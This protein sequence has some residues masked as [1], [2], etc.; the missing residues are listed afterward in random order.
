MARILRGKGNACLLAAMWLTGAAS[1]ALGQQSATGLCK[2]A[3]PAKLPEFEVATIKP[4]NPQGGIAGFWVYPGGRV[5]AGHM[6]LRMLLMFACNVQMFQVVG[7]PGWADKDF[8]NLQAKPSESSLSAKSN[9]PNPNF[10]PN[11]E[12]RQMLEALLI[13]RFQLK[14]H[15]ESR[16]G[17]VYVLERGSN[18]LKLDPVKDPNAPPWVGGAGKQGIFRLNGMSGQNISMPQLAASLSWF[19]QRP[20]IDRTGIEGSFDFEYKTGEDP[21][22]KAESFEEL[23]PTILTS[24]RGIGLKLTPAKGPVEAIVIDHAEEPSPN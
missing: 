6:N 7:G 20:V 8:F 17:P 21:D 12:Q 19:L 13:D 2:N 9:P 14:F 5:E 10:P 24:M 18:E 11:D 22:V 16:E 4:F 3:A 23:I 15:A 1:I